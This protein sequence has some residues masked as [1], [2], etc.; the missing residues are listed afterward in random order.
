MND[1]EPKAKAKR[2]IDNFV[3]G[4]VALGMVGINVGPWFQAQS[5]IKC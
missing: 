1:L 4:A 2:R 3:Y 5:E